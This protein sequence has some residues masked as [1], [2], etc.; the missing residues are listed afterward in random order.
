MALATKDF[1]RLH[2]DIMSQYKSFANSFVDIDDPQILEAL[3]AYD[4]EK[5]MWPDPLI[6]FNPSYLEGCSLKQLVDEGL[7]DSKKDIIFNGFHLYKHHQRWWQFADKRPALYRILSDKKVTLVTA[8][9]SK[10][11]AFAFVSTRQVLHEKL[12]VFP[13]EDKSYLILL[14]SVFHYLWAFKYCSTLGEGFCYTPEK[15]FGQFPFPAG[16]EPNR[17]YVPEEILA[18]EDADEQIKQHKATLDALGEKL[19]NQRKAIM[20]KIKI[21]LTNLYNLYHQENLSAVSIAKTA[22]CS[23]ADAEW[24]LGEF[25]KMRQVQVECDTAV[26]AAYGWSDIALNHGFYDLEFLPENDRRRYTV[27]LDARKEI[28]TRLLKLNNDRHKQ[29]LA[30]GLVDDT[31]KLLKKSPTP[32]PKKKKTTTADQIEL[33]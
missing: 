22:K 6:Q 19:D 12:V 16:F 21:G 17:E 2:D 9:V 32:K 28:M 29:E 24:A 11:V 3:K 33:L 5:S 27:C 26:A 1:F 15:I 10:A 30:A 7:L 8:R 23:E 18:A 25:M 31:G 13:F 20:L 14:Q 4:D